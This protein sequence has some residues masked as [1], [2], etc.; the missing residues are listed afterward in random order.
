MS[1]DNLNADLIRDLMRRVHDLETMAPVGFTDVTEGALRILSAEGLIVE[2]SAKV[3]GTLQVTGFLNGD[4]TI[5]WTGTS[6]FSGPTNITGPVDMTG[7]VDVLGNMAVKGG[8]NITA[9]VVKI[10][11][12]LGGGGGGI[13]ATS[14]TL[15]LT[16]NVEVNMTDA[17]VVG[18][19]TVTEGLRVGLLL[20]TTNPANVYA[21]SNGLLWRVS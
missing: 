10:G 17:K 14:G 4:G 6:N 16:S 13:E 11:P 8:G 9:G 15:Y 3:T 12:S 21:D 20:G 2:G 5:T 19:L 7:A 18:N 1:I